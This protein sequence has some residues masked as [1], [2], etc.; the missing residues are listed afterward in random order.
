MLGIRAIIR[1][2]SANAAAGLPHGIGRTHER[3]KNSEGCSNGSSLPSDTPECQ[4]CGACCFSEL[5]RYVRVTGDDY[6]RLGE[7]VEQL[8]H[9]IENRAYMQMRNGHCAALEFDGAAGQWACQVYTNRPQTC[10]DLERGSPACSG[11]RHAKSARVLGMHPFSKLAL[12]V[13]GS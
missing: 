7:E 8:V 6:D 5:N 1:S 9:F 4:H 10:R 12:N 2:H 13:L 11:E 3:M